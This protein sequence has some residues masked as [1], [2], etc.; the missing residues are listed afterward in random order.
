LNGN[1]GKNQENKNEKF[2][3]IPNIFEL[4]MINQASG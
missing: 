1:G 3:F 2:F 4:P